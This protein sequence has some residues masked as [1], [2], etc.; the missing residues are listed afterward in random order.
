MIE[1]KEDALHFKSEVFESF[2]EEETYDFAYYFAKNLKK[3]DI[4]TL[5]KMLFCLLNGLAR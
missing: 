2:S 1:I 5:M 3:G 4:I